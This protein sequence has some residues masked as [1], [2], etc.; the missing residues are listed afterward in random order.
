M[1]IK[2]VRNHLRIFVV[3]SFIAGVSLPSVSVPVLDI[4]PK[5]LMCELFLYSLGYYSK[6]KTIEIPGWIISWAFVLSISS[7][8]LFGFMELQWIAGVKKTLIFLVL[9]IAGFIWYV[10]FCEKIY[11]KNCSPVN[12]LL[13]NV[14]RYAVPIMAL[15]VIFFKIGTYIL[16]GGEVP[17][18]LLLKATQT[19]YGLHIR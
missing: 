7:P 8:V 1:R 9:G 15:H 6:D 18:I 17:I 3:M 19:S 4:M 5:R 13:R 12:C 16:A 2:L 10:S 11:A 14:N